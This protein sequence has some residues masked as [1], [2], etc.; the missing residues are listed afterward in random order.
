MIIDFCK[1]TTFYHWL[2]VQTS[3]LPFCVFFSTSAGYRYCLVQV[4]ADR[5][6]AISN[7]IASRLSTVNYST[8][9]PACL[10]KAGRQRMLAVGH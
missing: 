7:I 9:D 6:L 10:H 5:K 8:F 2:P 1:V 3:E 4:L